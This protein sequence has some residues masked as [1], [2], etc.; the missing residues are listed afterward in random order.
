MEQPAP[1]E[2]DGS[3]PKDRTVFLGNLPFTVDEKKLREVFTT[4]V[5]NPQSKPPL[6]SVA[7]LVW[8]GGRCTHRSKQIGP[9]E[10][11]CVLRVCT[12][13]LSTKSP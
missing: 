8:G 1:V 12:Q 11:L 2:T 10:G 3:D 7:L 4:E 13:D 5:S 6:L 9:V